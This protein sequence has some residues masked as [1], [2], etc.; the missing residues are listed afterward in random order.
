[1]L[2]KGLSHVRRNI[3]IAAVLCA[4]GVAPA[5]EPGSAPLPEI[6]QLPKTLVTSRVRQEPKKGESGEAGT[7]K[8][9][10]NDKR[11]AWKA[12]DPPGQKLTLGQCLQIGAGNHPAVRAAAASLAASERGYLALHNLPRLAEFVTPDLCAR[13]QQSQRGVLAAAAEVM[14]ARQENTYDVTR[15]Y[16]EYVRATQQEQTASEV[17]EQMEAFYDS[18]VEFLKL[19]V[20]DPRVKIN[21]FTLGTLD[22]L[23]GE[24]RELRDRASTGRKKALN[25]LQEAMAVDYEVVPADAELPLM[26]GVVTQEQVVAL[27]LSRRAELTQA[28][29]LLDV[30][31]LEVTAQAVQKRGVKVDTFASGSDLHARHL[32][33]PLRNGE[34]RPGVVVPEMPNQLVG[35]VDDRVARACEYVRRMEAMHDGVVR[36]VRT[37]VVNSFLDWQAATEQVRDT[38]ERHERQQKLVEKSRAAS[39]AKMDPELL[40]RNESLASQAQAR[41]VEAVYRQVLALIA[42]ERVTGG[43]IVPPFPGR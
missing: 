1:M 14:K 4:V 18:A 39:A 30:T 41:Y 15:L 21:E 7:G 10:G 20:P 35:R 22:G 27:A 40:V 19:E 26:T 29:A 43:G 25:A 24:V 11:P 28:G 33:A 6:P 17:V 16:F 32:P 37:E 38:R 31:R 9:N 5:S 34:Y 12:W 13:K 3:W 8:K 2:A 42:L 23:I 36:L